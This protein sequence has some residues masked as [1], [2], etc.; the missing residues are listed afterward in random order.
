MNVHALTSRPPFTV[1][2]TRA[3]A[4]ETKSRSSTRKT[5]LTSRIRDQNASGYRWRKTQTK[6]ATRN[7]KVEALPDLVT[8]SELQLVTWVLPMTIA[9]RVMNME[10]REIAV[11]LVAMALC[12]TLLHAY[13]S[14]QL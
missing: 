9:G 12:K 7:V 5:T 3:V 4:A 14:S 11:G 13:F 8:Y 6:I 10:Y 1:V 2:C